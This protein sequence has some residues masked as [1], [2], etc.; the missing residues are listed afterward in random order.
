MKEDGETPKQMGLQKKIYIER[1]YSETDCIDNCEIG[2][3]WASKLFKAVKKKA[4]T[5]INLC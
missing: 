4:I 2:D 3:Q 1:I 5:I